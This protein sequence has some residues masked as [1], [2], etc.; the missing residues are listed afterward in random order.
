MRPVTIA[1]TKTK[2]QTIELEALADGS[3][4]LY[5]D[6]CI[7]FVS[8]HDD[9]AYHGTLVDVPAARLGPA[10]F[11][12]LILGGGDGLAA[13]NLLRMPNLAHVTQVEIDPGMVRFCAD[14]PVVRKLNRDA[15]RDPRLELRCEDARSF[16][17]RPA[18]R[19]YNLVVVDF[20]DPEPEIVDLFRWPFYRQLMRHM[21]GRRGVVAVQASSAGSPV[22]MAVVHHLSTA[23]GRSASVLRFPGKHMEAGAIVV[24]DVRGPVLPRQEAPCPRLAGSPLIGTLV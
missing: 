22:E 24:G 5:L 17:G 14:H 20:P 12:A 18:R 8:G 4:A 13:R 7:Q 10:P 3:F 11:S 9:V 2:F 16:I 1:R 15:F 6:G 23:M 21:D 19:A